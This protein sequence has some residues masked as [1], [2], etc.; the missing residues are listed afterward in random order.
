MRSLPDKEATLAAQVVLSVVDHP[1]GLESV[2]II[3]K[4]ARSRAKEEGL[5]ETDVD[6]IVKHG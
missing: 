3:S 4:K 6:D 2:E 5:T 1:H